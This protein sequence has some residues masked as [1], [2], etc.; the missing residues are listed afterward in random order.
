[1]L[2]IIAVI[3]IAI[4]ALTI[5]SFTAH[6]IFSPLVLVIIGILLWLRFR[7]GRSHL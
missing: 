3:L 7:P 4:V 1:M 5:L 6:L 2:A